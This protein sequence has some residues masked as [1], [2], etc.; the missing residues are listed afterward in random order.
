[1]ER[2]RAHGEDQLYLSGAVEK[3]DAVCVPQSHVYK[4]EKDT[5]TPYKHKCMY[6]HTCLHM[7]TEYVKCV[8]G[9]T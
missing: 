7:I 1:M 3:Q 9:C 8:E 5:D 6:V 2:T 4:T